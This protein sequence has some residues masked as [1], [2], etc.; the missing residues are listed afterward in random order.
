MDGQ[1][2]EVKRLVELTNLW[3]CIS[4]QLLAAI[5]AA[6][7]A[8]AQA[9]AAKTSGRPLGLPLFKKNTMKNYRLFL[10][11]IGLVCCSLN[12]DTSNHFLSVDK[13]PPVVIIFNSAPEAVKYKKGMHN[14]LVSKAQLF[15]ISQNKQLTFTP[16]VNSIDTLAISIDKKTIEVEHSLNGLD[17]LSFLLNAGDTLLFEYRNGIPIANNRQFAKDG[18]ISAHWLTRTFVKGDSATLVTQQREF[19]AFLPMTFRGDETT[20]LFQSIKSRADKDYKKQIE[21]V[22]SLARS[23]AISTNVE[24][25]LKLKYRFEQFRIK[26]DDPRI[27]LIKVNLPS[28]KID[29][30]E[31]AVSSVHHD[32]LMQYT[33]YHDILKLIYKAE[34]RRVS[35]FKSAGVNVPNYR[36]LYD[37]IV[38][39][40]LPRAIKEFFLL[41][42]F[43]D[44]VPLSSIE[45]T[46]GY[47]TKLLKDVHDS[48]A[49]QIVIANHNLDDTVTDDLR[50]ERLDGSAT[51]LSS[52]LSKYKGKVVYVDFWASW[53]GPCIRLFPASKEAEK[54]FHSNVIFLYLSKDE[55]RER[56]SNATP[57]HGIG[58]SE[59]NFIITNLRTSKFLQDLQI[60]AIPRYLVFDRN[61]TLI[62]KNAPDPSNKDLEKILLSLSRPK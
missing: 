28:I 19:I 43:D 23:N 51:T 3:L 5:G 56:W 13:H 30:I 55:E 14:S 20:I 21:R 61:G 41:Q 39:K 60:Q 36:Q 37:T 6:L 32:S 22:D 18:D 16:R 47:K 7:V 52:L 9:I 26:I 4:N 59:T 58:T 42:A 34:G 38:V 10:L 11:A 53:C 54:K 12:K 1:A 35:R 15:Y 2:L 50:L 25:H 8:E 29:S 62:H 17:R 33:F 27:H 46:Q 44:L 49:A 45:A 48:T 31:H 40:I 24:A 57:K